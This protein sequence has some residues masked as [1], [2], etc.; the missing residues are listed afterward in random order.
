[1]KKQNRSGSPL[2]SSY[3]NVETA[4]HLFFTCGSA[5]VICGILGAFF[6]N[7]TCPITIWQ[8]HAWLFKFLPKRKKIHTLVTNALC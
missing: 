2:C 1:L 3:A 8:S 7:N 6:G 4:N 5:K